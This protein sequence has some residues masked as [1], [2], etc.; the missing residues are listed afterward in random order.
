MTSN[1][2]VVKLKLSDRFHLMPNS[3]FSNSS[4]ASAWELGVSD[5][6]WSPERGKKDLLMLT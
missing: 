2:A 4:G 1:I 3:L 5:K 6:N